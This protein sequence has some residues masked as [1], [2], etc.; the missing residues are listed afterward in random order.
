MKGGPPKPP[1][2]HD[3]TRPSIDEAQSLVRGTKPQNDGP[4]QKRRTEFQNVRETTLAT[5]GSDMRQTCATLIANLDRRGLG[6]SGFIADNGRRRL[7]GMTFRGDQRPP[8]EIFSEGMP[9][10]ARGAEAAADPRKQQS[11]KD[12]AD[13][14]LVSTSR[15][16]KVA[17]EHARGEWGG[18]Y[19]YVMHEQKGLDV[20]R[21]LGDDAKRDQHE[22][23]VPDGIRRERVV[24]AY[25]VDENGIIPG[26][27]FRNPNFDARPFDAKPLHEQRA[28]LVDY[29]DMLTQMLAREQK[30]RAS[31]NRKTREIAR[32]QREIATTEGAITDLMA[33][34]DAVRSGMRCAGTTSACRRRRLRPST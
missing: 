25:A 13:S 5:V 3:T 29:H 7:C 1:R 24:G 2:S 27:F 30:A 31:C 19:L 32:L 34:L 15:S 11:S 23:A 14:N 8:D 9:A 6:E 10:W 33:K 16:P 26:S 18:G 12:L 4:R 22:V 17:A 28:G 20:N 21:L